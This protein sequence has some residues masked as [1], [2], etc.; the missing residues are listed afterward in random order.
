MAVYKLKDLYKNKPEYGAS[1]PSLKLGKY[2]YVRQS[3]IRNKV[4]NTFVN[5]GPLLR[6]NDLLISRVGANAGETYIHDS[7]E[8]CVFAG[9]LV[10]YNFDNSKINKKYFYYWTKTNKYKNQIK[11]LITGSG[12]PQFNPPIVSELRIFVPSIQIQKLIIDIIK[13]DESL[14]LR[15]SN[16]V[17][18]D[19]F[20][21]AK[22]DMKN[23]IDIIKPLEKIE[24]KLINIK[25]KLIKILINLYNY[26]NNTHQIVF[27][28]VIKI[29]SSKYENQKKYFATNA[30]GELEIDYQ[31]IIPLSEKIPSR[32]NVSPLKD[33]FI[34]SKL[35]GENKIF[36]F[37]EKPKEVFSTGFFN[38]KTDYHDHIL[39]F[40][41]FD[42]FKLQKEYFSTGTTMQGINNSSL[43]LIKLNH[44]N[45]KSN[46]ITTTLYDLENN[47]IKIKTLKT[48][49]IEL[50]IK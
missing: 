8:K 18:I 50:L 1:L 24:Y 29:L 49:L 40:M 21:N 15:H 25:N 3:D 19:T 27:N 31:K 44:S 4:F 41:L 2:K 37:K 47:L 46:V 30:V 32:A 33:S 26:S 11:K 38:F 9:F 42:E 35:A 43:A 20:E 5:S 12:Q 17:R 6:K 23:L 48:K 22:V 36:Y 45:L 16:C 14:F 39:G 28:S 7:D 34:F 13:Q 10:R